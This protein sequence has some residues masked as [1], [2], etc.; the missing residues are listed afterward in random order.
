M[1]Y[2]R[3]RPPSFLLDKSSRSSVLDFGAL[4][5]ARMAPRAVQVPSVARV[6]TSRSSK[7]GDDIVEPVSIN[8]VSTLIFACSL[9]CF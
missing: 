7:S 3:D 8:I 1:Y 5:P 6:D 4:R 2:Q 9:T